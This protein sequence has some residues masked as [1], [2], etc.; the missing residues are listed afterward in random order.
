M[1]ILGSLIWIIGA[2]CLLIG[3]SSTMSF[4]EDIGIILTLIGGVL[5]VFPII[6]A[7]IFN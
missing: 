4:E 1:I 6:L 2:L 3:M 7:I 5:I